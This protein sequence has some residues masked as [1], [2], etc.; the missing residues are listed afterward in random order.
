LALGNAVS[1]LG[2]LQTGE[3]RLGAG[4][5]PAARLV[6]RTT[7]Q[8]ARSYPR[9]RVHLQIDNR[10]SLHQRLRNEN[11]ELFVA[12]TREQQGDE[13]LN[14]IALQQSPGVIFCRPAHP[15]LS[16]NPPSLL[17]L[18]DYPLAGTPTQRGGQQPAKPE[19][20]RADIGYRVRQLYA[21]QGLRGRQR[22]T[23]QGAL[24]CSGRRGRERA[25][26]LTA[27]T[28]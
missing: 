20:Q 15:L 5:Y 11:I 6:P 23:R 18:Q 25:A 3:L 8:L 4:P 12:D 24:G 26:G 7:G 16:R 19:Q 21:T 2:K 17:D 9:M 13:R 28:R 1:Q 14:I 10:E 27:R 22:R